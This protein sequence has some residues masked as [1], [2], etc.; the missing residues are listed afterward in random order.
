VST[1][2]IF[3]GPTDQKLWVFEVFKRSLGRAGMCW[4]QPARVDHMCKKKRAGRR[5]FIYVFIY[6][7]KM[8]LEHSIVASG[9]LLVASWIGHSDHWSLGNQPS[10]SGLQ[11]SGDQWLSTTGQ[12]PRLTGNHVPIRLPN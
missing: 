11:N 10:A 1:N 6:F 8:R 4:S 12:R 2:F 7:H 5:S 9:Q 3:F